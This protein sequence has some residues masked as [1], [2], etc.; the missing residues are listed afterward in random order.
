[1]YISNGW[2]ITN[3]P[4]R[5]WVGYYNVP[6][7]WVRYYKCTQA[8]GGILQMYLSSGWDTTNLH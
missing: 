3:V 7:Q 6:K 1:M 5:Q 2:D 8:M 4:K